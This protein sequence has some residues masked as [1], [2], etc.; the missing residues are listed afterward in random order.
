MAGASVSWTNLWGGGLLFPEAYLTAT[1]Q[2]VAHKFKWSLEDLFL[3]ISIDGGKGSKGEDSFVLSGLT[4]EGADWDANEGGG[5]GALAL[6]SAL[7]VELP[8][9]TFRWA[10]K[11]SDPVVGE[12]LKGEESES[13]ASISVPIYLNFM[14][15]ELVTSVRLR[16]P[17]NI[18]PAVWFQRG[19]SLLLWRKQ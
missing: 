18:P 15:T 17:N 8:P 10:N 4:L 19:V 11:T 14:R 1:R 5:K 7:S 13:P 9:V 16:V 12:L 3:I 2:A 6:S